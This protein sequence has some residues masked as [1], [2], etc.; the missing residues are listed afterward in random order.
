MVRAGAGVGLLG[1]PVEGRLDVAAVALEVL[2]ARIARH[3][4]HRADGEAQPREGQVDR[5]P[6]PGVERDEAC[7]GDRGG[8]DRPLRLA[9]NHDDAEPSAP[10]LPARHVGSHGH[11]A[12]FAQGLH[13][14]HVSMAAAAI[15]AAAGGARPPNELHVETLQRLAQ[16]AR[17]AV[18]R[19]HDVDWIARAWGLDERHQHE[20]AVPHA[21]DARQ[22]LELGVDLLCHGRRLPRRAMHEA[23]VAGE[24]APQHTIDKCAVLRVRHRQ[25]YLAR[26]Q[27]CEE[28]I[29]ALYSRSK[30]YL[31]SLDSSGCP[32]AFPWGGRSP[33][34]NRGCGGSASV[35]EIEKFVPSPPHAVTKF[36]DQDTR[37][38]RTGPPHR[39]RR[40]RPA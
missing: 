25:A 30:A 17:V 38:S 31:E 13:R 33:L 8:Q 3:A 40:W 4:H 36:R 7:G 14:C 10:R 27:P 34:R 1:R 20:L 21:N 32:S 16:N 6:A 39:A 37:G 19:Q 22:V 2:V 9:R 26:A 29:R 15:L 5:H 35:I 24:Q 18:A 12:A 23:D 11:P 28:T